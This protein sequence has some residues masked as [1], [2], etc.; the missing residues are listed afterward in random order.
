MAAVSFRRVV[1]SAALLLSC[2]WPRT[3]AAQAIL[4]DRPVKAGDL[5][6][7]PGIDEPLAY[8]YVSDK[9]HLATTTDGGPQFSFLRYVE[10]VRSG[11]DQ[12]EAREGEGGGI[13]HA[14]VAL[15]VTPE[16]LRDAQRELQRTRPGARIVGPVVYRSGKFGLVTSFLDP[17][18]GLSRKV[19]GLGNAP[20][21][22]GEK[23]AVSLHLTK[24]GAKVL[25]ESFQTPTPD[26]SFTFEMDIQG[27]R[28]P[29][30]ALIEADFDQIYEHEAFGAGIA[31]SF[32]AAEIKTAFDDLQRKGAIKVTQIGEDAQLDQLVATAYNKLIEMMFEPLNGTGT[33]D[34]ASLTGAAGGGSSLLDRAT[35]MYDKG[36]A[37]AKEQ[38]EAARKRRAEGAEGAAE[39]AK[40]RRDAAKRLRESADELDKSVKEAKAGGGESP[41]Y[42]AS[43]ERYAQG[44][45]EE[46]DEADAEAVDEEKQAS[47]TGQ[48]ASAPP[49]AIVAAYEMK[50]VRHRGLFRIDLNKYTSDTMTL[51]F[52]ENIGDLRRLAADKEHFRQVNLDDPLYRQREI[53]AFVDGLNSQDFGK[54]VNFVTLQMRKRHHGGDQTLDEVRID[55]NNFNREGNAF[56]VLYGWKGD[57]DRRRWL[58]Y[59]YRTLWSFFGGAEVELPWQ[60]GSAP[61]INLAPPFQ[62]LPVTLEATDMEVLSKAGVRAIN[63]K[64]YSTVAGKQTVRQETLNAT[65]GEL[66]RTVELIVPKDAP[67]YEYEIEWMLQGN[68]RLTSGR[69]H[70]SAGI[71]FVDGLPES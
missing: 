61:A 62:R 4:L 69:Q 58:D 53:V 12:P 32:L 59:E 21:L 11:A 6:V 14:L 23:A 18:S 42:A 56:K 20:L 55:R 37:E 13:V 39:R 15:A 49:F 63:V 19:V 26:I 43:L 52:D 48:E 29:K 36:R 24:L 5:T 27:F 25:W 2:C 9:P 22:D 68:R 46:A 16:Q 66:S 31:S 65:K 33:P 45:R 8:Y 60:A 64:L 67:D 38:N 30:R 71:L 40:R 54:Y 51:R 70:A 10:N 44:F 7:F 47:E 28:S 57:D 3:A 17:E 1:W 41:E 34:L 50:R 35:A